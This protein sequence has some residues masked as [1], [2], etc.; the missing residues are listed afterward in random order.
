[1]VTLAE[2]TESAQR[3]AA[4]TLMNLLKFPGSEPLLIQHEAYSLLVRL[5]NIPNI[6]ADIKDVC[7]FGLYFQASYIPEYV[8]HLLLKGIYIFFCF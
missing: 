5:A 2:G 7:I 4:I 8:K 6:K 3:Y 1:M